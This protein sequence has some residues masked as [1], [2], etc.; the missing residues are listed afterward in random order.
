LGAHP[1]A[2][3][4]RELLAHAGL[5]G[6]EPTAV[7]R[8][9][10]TGLTDRELAVLELLAEGRTNRQI[11]E[12]LFMSPKTASVHVSRILQKLGVENRTEAAAAGRRAGLVR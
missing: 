11:G 2:R 9:A 10:G 4:A 3:E 1:L 7:D 6:R 5:A 8:P 12:A